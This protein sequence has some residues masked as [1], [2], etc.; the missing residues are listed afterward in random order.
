MCSTLAL[1]PPRLGEVPVGRVAAE[2]LLLVALGPGMRSSLLRMQKRG[3][4]LPRS[5]D[6][7][8]GVVN[9]L[10]FFS[11]MLF[12]FGLSGT[13]RLLLLDNGHVETRRE[14]SNDW[15]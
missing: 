14:Q 4:P 6:A 13:Q 3:R 5:A 11:L 1:S 10:S 2:L 8:A 15:L 12:C 7:S 9:E